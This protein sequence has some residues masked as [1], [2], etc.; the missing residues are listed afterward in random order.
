VSV[1]WRG[2]AEE[3]LLPR[4]PHNL[5]SAKTQADFTILQGSIAANEDVPV[6]NYTDSLH[7]QASQALKTL[8][9]VPSSVHGALAPLS[10]LDDWLDI[11][12]VFVYSP[13]W[14]AVHQTV[15][16][17]KSADVA[18]NSAWYWSR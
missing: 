6:S 15:V 16:L 9:V 7:R 17:M 13:T 4:R 3:R 18:G 14:T 8:R 1:V 11:L 2:G 10:F 5:A 12:T